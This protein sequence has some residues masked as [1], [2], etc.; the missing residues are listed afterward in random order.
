MKP[1]SKGGSKVA[2]KPHHKQAGNRT[3]KLSFKYQ[4]ALDT[5][6]AEIEALEEEIAALEARLADPELFAKNPDIST[7]PPTG[8]PPRATRR[9]TRNSAGWKPRKRLRR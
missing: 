2:A 4:H 8:S 5:L 9:M 1:V 7:S 6:P 3:A